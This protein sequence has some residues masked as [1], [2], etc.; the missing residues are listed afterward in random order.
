LLIGSSRVIRL[1]AADDLQRLYVDQQYQAPV[2]RVHYAR[3]HWRPLLP[4]IVGDD[5]PQVGEWDSAVKYLHFLANKPYNDPSSV[6]EYVVRAIEIWEDRGNS[7]SDWA[8][9]KRQ[10]AQTLGFLDPGNL[11][12]D[13]EH[14][15]RSALV[16]E[17]LGFEGKQ[18]AARIDAALHADHEPAPSVIAELLHSALTLEYMLHTAFLVEYWEHLREGSSGYL[19]TIGDQGAGDSDLRPSVEE[20]LELVQGLCGLDKK[21]SS[22]L[23]AWTTVHVPCVGS[24]AATAGAVH[25]ADAWHVRL[26]WKSSVELEALTETGGKK[27]LMRII[28][29]P[30]AGERLTTTG[31]VKHTPVKGKSFPAL[32]RGDEWDAFGIRMRNGDLQL[33]GPRDEP[34]T[35][36]H[37]VAIKGYNHNPFD[38][39]L[40]GAIDIRGRVIV[41]R[42][43]R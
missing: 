23:Q 36:V 2:M 29:Q 1:I 30:A 35:Y 27:T 15:V 38:I 20:A 25:S 13:A 41:L 40:I 9:V 5:W 37:D 34:F 18:L 43:H 10:L 16:P 19:R 17:V 31:Q 22:S 26:E 39:A 4:D 6:E 33:R 32:N 24:D 42:I 11:G 12:F 3:S 14:S 21:P 28:G 7:F 8:N